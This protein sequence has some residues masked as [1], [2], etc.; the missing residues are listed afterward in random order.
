[1]EYGLI[2]A[3]IAVAILGTVNLLGGQLGAN[4]QAVMSALDNRE[5][6]TIGSATMK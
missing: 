6:H 4:F 5:V 1:M 3:G 2:A